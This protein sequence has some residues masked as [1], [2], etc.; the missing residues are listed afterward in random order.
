MKPL[1]AVA[2]LWQAW[3]E[4]PTDAAHHWSMYEHWRTRLARWGI[5]IEGARV[6][7]IGTGDRA[8]MALLFAADGASVTALDLFVVQVGRRRPLMWARR[9]RQDGVRVVARMVVRDAVHTFRYW[10]ALKAISGHRLDGERVRYV[11]ADAAALP[12]PDQTFDLVVSSA[13][14]EHLPDLPAAT[15]ESFRVLRPGGV[16]IIQIAL[17]PG[18][19][20]GHHAAWHA[21]FHGAGS[22]RPWDHLYNDHRPFPLYLNG[23]RESDYQ[24]A[25]DAVYENVA[26][27]DG[28]LEGSDL[29]T[30]EI[31]T[32]LR[33]FSE[34]DLLLSSTTAW[35]R[36]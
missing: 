23:L 35:A 29:L 8:P 14:W 33:G 2:R 30:S 22:I 36:R 31:R 11:R 21:G 7:D 10:R 9:L 15:A 3:S 17:F 32:A 20:G 34:R 24:A 12:F 28:P 25:F 16:A 6:L 4:A 5:G 26:W 19:Q 27:D 13:V 1:E 18:L